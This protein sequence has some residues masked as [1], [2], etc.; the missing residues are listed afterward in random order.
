MRPQLGKVGIKIEL[1]PSPDFPT[2]ARRISNYDYDLDIDPVF[3]WGDPVIGVA[4]TYMSSNVRKG[5]VWANMSGYKNPKVDELLTQ[6][7]VENSP[8][9]RDELYKE[10]QK[11]VNQ[12]LPVAWITTYP[13]N[14][15]YSKNLLN[16]PEGIWGAFE[17]FNNV[18]W[19]K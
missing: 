11:I 4:R 14:T 8:E 19:S 3:N 9:K 15:I 18:V 10:F 1:R 5:V 13:S 7:A 16:L 2:W 12:E 6:A 17:P